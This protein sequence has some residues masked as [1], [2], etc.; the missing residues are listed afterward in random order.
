MHCKFVTC[1]S[2]THQK[3]HIFDVD[4]AWM[5][6]QQLYKKSKT[7]GSKRMDRI[8]FWL[9]YNGWTKIKLLTHLIFINDFFL[10]IKYIL[11]SFNPSMTQHSKSHDLITLF[12]SFLFVLMAS[13]C[14]N[15]MSYKIEKSALGYIHT[16]IHTYTHIYIHT[17]I[18]H[19]NKKI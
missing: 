1:K 15:V 2:Q 13:Y 9:N 7:R 3:D 8:N 19:Q 4:G 11:N 14:D 18:T 5:R 12:F 16:H 10:K 17:H 6:A